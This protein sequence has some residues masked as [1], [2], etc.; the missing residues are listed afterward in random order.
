M[1]KVVI[2]TSK[3]MDQEVRR[4]VHDYRVFYASVSDFG[5]TAIRNE[6]LRV[7]KVETKERGD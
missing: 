1:A 3:A 4:I 7:R 6:I 2:I 5:K